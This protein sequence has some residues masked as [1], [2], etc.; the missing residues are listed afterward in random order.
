ME[1]NAVCHEA[2]SHVPIRV[3]KEFGTHAI[4]DALMP[5]GRETVKDAGKEFLLYYMTDPHRHN[6]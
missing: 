6:R 2:D 5:D 1:G 3:G 4:G